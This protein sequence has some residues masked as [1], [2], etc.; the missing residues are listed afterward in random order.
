MAQEFES[1]DI[2]HHTASKDKTEDEGALERLLRSN[3]YEKTRFNDVNDSIQDLADELGLPITQMAL[4]IVD[5][6]KLDFEK[7]QK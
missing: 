7:I 5:Q 1:F 3:S 2:E 6:D 4:K